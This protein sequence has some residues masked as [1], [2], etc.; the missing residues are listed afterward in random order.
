MLGELYRYWHPACCTLNVLMISA[1]VKRLFRTGLPAKELERT[2]Y[3]NETCF[4]AHA[5]SLSKSSIAG[6]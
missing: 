4:G 5:F 3:P 1:P 6:T 2:L